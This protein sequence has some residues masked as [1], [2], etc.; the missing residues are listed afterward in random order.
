[1]RNLIQPVDSQSEIVGNV[2]EE[3]SSDGGPTQKLSSAGSETPTFGLGDLAKRE[4]KGKHFLNIEPH[5]EK[6]TS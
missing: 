2:S 6:F 5:S 1:M 3:T 4:L